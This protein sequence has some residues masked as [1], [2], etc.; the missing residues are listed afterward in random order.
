MIHST[1][2]LPPTT[3][4]S[5]ARDLQAPPRP[6]RVALL[7][8]GLIGSA[9]ADALGDDPSL[10]PS[11]ALV[12]DRSRKRASRVH[13]WT[14]SLEEVL[15]SSP[16]VAVECLGGIEPAA[17][18]CERLL[19]AGV[20][21]VSANKQMVAASLPRLAEAARLSGAQ[22]RFDAA[23]CAGVPVLDAVAR[24][25]TAGIQ[26]IRAVLNGTTQ[27][28]IDEVTRS[29]APLDDCLAQAIALGY[30]EPDPSADLSGRDSADKLS[31]LCAAAG[32]GSIAADEIPTRGLTHGGERL[33]TED[34]RDL[35]RW[36]ALRLVARLDVVT[37]SAP[38]TGA[39]CGAGCGAGGGAGGAPDRASVRLSVEPTLVP[40]RSPIGS[41]SQTENIVEVQTTRAGVMTVRGPGAGAQP[42]IAALLADIDGV[43]R[44]GP[45]W[46]T[47]RSTALRPQSASSERHRALRVSSLATNQ[48]L[49]HSPATRV[50][51]QLSTMAGSQGLTVGA[52]DVDGGRLLA[53]L[54][55]SPEGLAT[56]E[57]ELRASGLRTRSVAIDPSVRLFA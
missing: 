3:D 7:G 10:E 2:L 44:G 9:L 43:I 1:L 13:Q 56:I 20:P 18:F 21:V 17:T 32:L 23:V 36:G 19:R 40:R 14:D 49:L 28:I 11:I 30:A 51:E 4:R 45:G 8:C 31:L 12:R 5:A 47:Q 41:V 54:R 6:V 53:S 26:S 48:S 55:G 39:G 27:W 35:Q 52:I 15:A 42:T 33:E 50:H 46:T 29:G 34:I 25:R 16:D 38:Q 24:L 22:L 57:A 37:D